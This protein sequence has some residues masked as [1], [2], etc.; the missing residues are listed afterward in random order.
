MID[1][2][3]RCA[4]EKGVFAFRAYGQK[5]PLPQPAW[6]YHSAGGVL[7]IDESRVA[8]TLASCALQGVIGGG[9]GSPTPCAHWYRYT[10][11][12]PDGVATNYSVVTVA[13][14]TQLCDAFAQALAVNS[15]Q[16]QF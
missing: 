7:V 15:P 12:A 4:L 9:P 14:H 10:S 6:L 1:G 8:G 11:S 13:T 3:T 2:S 16:Q 5:T